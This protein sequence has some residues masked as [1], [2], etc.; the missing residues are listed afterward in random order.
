MNNRFSGE[1]IIAINSFLFL[2]VLFKYVIHII[3]FNIGIA[4]SLLFLIKLGI[5]VLCSFIYLFIHI[6]KFKNN[7]NKSNSYFIGKLTYRNK[8]SSII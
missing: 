6:I 2:G 1:N 7:E 8:S 5:F 3:L 4:D